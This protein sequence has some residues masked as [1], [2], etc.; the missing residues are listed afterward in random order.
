[1]PEA[2]LRKRKKEQSKTLLLAGPSPKQPEVLSSRHLHILYS[3]SSQSEA[4]TISQTYTGFLFISS[5]LAG[6][7]FIYFVRWV[8]L[9]AETSLCISSY[10][11]EES[12]ICYKFS[13]FMDRILGAVGAFKT[14]V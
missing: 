9:L 4:H 5:I 3:P 2:E 11:L 10:W 7:G 12:G 1:M 8:K 6:L 13:E 14:W